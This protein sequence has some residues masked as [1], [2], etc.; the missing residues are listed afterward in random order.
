MKNQPRPTLYSPE[1]DNRSHASKAEHC[2]CRTCTLLRFGAIRLTEGGENGEAV[3][4]GVDGRMAHDF[5]S[6]AEAYLFIQ[7]HERAIDFS[8]CAADHFEMAERG[9]DPAERA[10]AVGHFEAGL[11]TF[12]E[13]RMA[14]EVLRAA[15]LMIE[16][17]FAKHAPVQP[18]KNSTEVEE[19]V[20]KLLPNPRKRKP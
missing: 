1:F 4:A 9:G 20:G 11:K 14:I 3:G 5:L 19:L 10:A 13:E 6:M 8:S 18:L 7:F 15:I 16:S 12:A 17:E 2:E